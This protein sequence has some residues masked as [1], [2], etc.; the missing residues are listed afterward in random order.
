MPQNRCNRQAEGSV[1]R[2]A[3]SGTELL[4]P[5][6]GAHLS[7]AAG[8]GSISAMASSAEREQKAYYLSSNSAV[9][10]N[11]LFEIGIFRAGTSRRLPAASAL[12]LPAPQVPK[13]AGAPT[14]CLT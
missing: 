5:S 13:N 7:P 8:G 9:R 6:R 2:V 10:R 3:N 11:Q 12:V 14:Q 1:H 4:E